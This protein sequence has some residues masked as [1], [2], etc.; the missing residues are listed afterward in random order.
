MTYSDVLFKLQA[1]SLTAHLKVH[2]KDSLPSTPRPRRKNPGPKRNMEPQRPHMGP[3]SHNPGAPHMGPHGQNMMPPHGQNVPHGQN[4]SV[5][6]SV[7]VHPSVPHDLSA[8]VQM[9]PAHHTGHQMYTVAQPNGT[10]LLMMP[11]QYNHWK[12]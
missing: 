2:F 10:T 5:P 11:D 7:P 8:A 4:L 3:H 12:M 1:G 9:P 6:L